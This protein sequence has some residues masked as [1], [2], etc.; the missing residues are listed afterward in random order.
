MRNKSVWRGLLLAGLLNLSLGSTVALADNTALTQK[1]AAL[2]KSTGGR[3]GVAWID[4][5]GL[6]Y[7]YRADER[8]PMTSTFKT[9][10]A[11]AILHN[12]VSQPNL[13]EKKIRIREADRVAWTPVTG[14]YFGKEMSIAALCAAAIEYS[15]NLAAN[16]LLKELG[17]PQGV[18]AYARLLGDTLTRLDRQETEL[19]S[20]APGD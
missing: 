6:R 13:L 19:N 4:G 9:L 7:G 17:G 5:D 20:A 11:A 10:A 16:Y 15:D 1:L 3:L 14:N 2:E 12:S 8:F 18:T